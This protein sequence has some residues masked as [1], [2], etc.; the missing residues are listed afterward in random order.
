MKLHIPQLF[1]CLPK[2]PKLLLVLLTTVEMLM[3]YD[4]GAIASVLPQVKSHWDLSGKQE[5][6]IGSAFIITFSIGSAVFA[7]LA[8]FVKVNIIMA[9][10]LFV[11]TIRYDD[12]NFT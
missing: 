3:F 9:F 2:H 1:G 8:N 12:L 6:I 10:G 7:Y 11:W 5:G 4:R